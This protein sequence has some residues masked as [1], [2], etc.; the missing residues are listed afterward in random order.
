MDEI[1]FDDIKSDAE[2][3]ETQT[4]APQLGAPASVAGETSTK[5]NAEE[6]A[7]EN[8]EENAEEP[9]E[10]NAEKGKKD[11][12]P[13]GKPDS[14]PAGVKKRFSKLSGELRD[15][16]AKMQQMQEA[17][18][19]FQ[20]QSPNQNQ[21]KTLTREDFLRAGKTETDY[22]NHLVQI[23]TRDQ[24]VQMQQHMAQQAQQKQDADEISS[25]WQSAME[26]AKADLPDYDDVIAETQV[27]LPVA[28]MRY[29]ATSP[30]GPYVAYTIGKREDI[31]KHINSVPPEHRHAE[32][33]K[34]EQQVKTWLSKRT[35][36]GT[37]P[38]PPPSS[39]SAPSAPQPPRPRAP[40][41]LGARGQ[42]KLD[43]ATAS[44]E[45]WLG[46]N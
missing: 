20:S 14:V 4:G 38:P 44:I 18:N 11:E 21:Q 24:M 7:E 26:N 37:T 29:L 28:S 34:V 41:I 8:T 46:M 31:Q 17:L 25:K 5:E 30:L 43:P 2:I 19:F 36:A 40:K 10:E 1:N 27:Q 32:I 3:K 45:D 6:P 42:I 9:A 16:K 12:S 23:S 13:W 33:L 39:P 22:I 35:E 15:T